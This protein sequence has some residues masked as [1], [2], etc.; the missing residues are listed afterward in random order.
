MVSFSGQQQAQFAMECDAGELV[1]FLDGFEKKT[2]DKLLQR[3]VGAGAL[4][5]SQLVRKE[6][7]IGPTGNLRRAVGRV[8]LKG[9]VAGGQVNYL[10]GALK[11]KAKSKASAAHF[12]LVT[13]GTKARRRTFIGG[14]FK[15]YNRRGANNR[16]TGI[17]PANPFVVRTAE[18]GRM[19]IANAIHNQ[20]AKDLASGKFT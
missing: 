5:G 20:A 10:F 3:A 4:K 6:T 18:Q 1:K 16:G 11:K 12:H 19:Q 15:A 7:P 13:G 9:K 8:R 14:K 17:M 2:A